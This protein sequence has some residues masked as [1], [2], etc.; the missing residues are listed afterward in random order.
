[1]HDGL[2]VDSAA[3]SDGASSPENL[4]KVGILLGNLVDGAKEAARR[5][6]ALLTNVVLDADGDTVERAN[7]L[8]RLGK[9]VVELLGLLEG[10]VLE[11]LEDAVC[12]LA[13]VQDG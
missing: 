13:S 7:G 6:V 9:L 10:L 4:H 3:V 8:A 1:M 2:A 11:E 12:S 5:S